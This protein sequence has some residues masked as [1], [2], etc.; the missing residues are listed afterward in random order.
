MPQ[1]D[2]DIDALA[3]YLHLTPP[4]VLKMADRGKL[5]GRKIKGQWRF[6]PAEIHHWLEERIGI[7]DEGELVQMESVLNQGG[8]GPVRESPTISRLLA[9]SAIRIPLPARTKN[10]VITSMI[11]V[12]SEAGLLWDPEKMAD[13][14]RNRENLHPTAMDSGVA[15]LHPRRP[16]PSILPEASLAFG[17]TSHGVP[18]GGPAGQLT[19]MFFLILSTDDAGH[20]Q[21]LAR[22][23]RLLTPDF[24]TAAREAEDGATLLDAV[25]QAEEE[26]EG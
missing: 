16:M 6:S 2:F 26:L 9:P 23:S 15:L 7:S 14:V 8:G 22:L 10:S 20:L 1:E 12:A 3:A 11:K 18:F 17:R 24:L 5:P 25:R 13:A 19:D 21:V 4:Q